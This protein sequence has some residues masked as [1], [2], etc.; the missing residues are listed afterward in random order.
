MGFLIRIA[1]LLGLVILFIPADEAETKKLTG[2]QSVSVFDTIGFATSAY[3]DATGF[4]GRNPQ[5]CSTGGILVDTFEAKARTGARWIYAWLDPAK[6]ASA[7]GEQPVTEAAPD[8]SAPVVHLPLRGPLATGSVRTT[9]P[10][11][12]ETLVTITPHPRGDRHLPPPPPPR[13]S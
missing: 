8:S 12:T 5:A 6:A 11:P 2:G 7:P 1:L 9:V 4:C 3:S 13:P 10:Q